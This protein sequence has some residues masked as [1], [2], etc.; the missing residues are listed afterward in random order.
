MHLRSRSFRSQEY[1]IRIL[2][3]TLVLMGRDDP[4]GAAGGPRVGVVQGVIDRT[5]RRGQAHLRPVRRHR[6][7]ERSGAGTNECSHRPD[8]V[9]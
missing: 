6:R 5:E 9:T 8:S 4:E 3:D 2:P 1:L 7:R